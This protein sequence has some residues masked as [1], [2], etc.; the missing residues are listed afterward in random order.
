VHRVT[1]RPRRCTV[2]TGGGGQAGGGAYAS[3]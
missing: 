3:R 2:G 1:V